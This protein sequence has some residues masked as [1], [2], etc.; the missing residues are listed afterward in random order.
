MPI[1]MFCARV[2]L[3]A[4]V[5]RATVFPVAVL[6]HASLLPPPRAFDAVL[7]FWVW[8]MFCV[9]FVMSR[10]RLVVTRIGQRS[11]HVVDAGHGRA[12]VWG[13]GWGSCRRERRIRLGCG[14]LT[15][16]VAWTWLTAC[17]CVLSGRR[18]V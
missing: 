17:P 4:A 7:V 18:M 9:G 1:Q 6:Y 13:G 2:L 12:L 10:F 16:L 11:S 8:L 5:V 15:V 14:V 3:D